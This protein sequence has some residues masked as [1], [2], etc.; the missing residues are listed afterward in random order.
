MVPR[1]PFGEVRR[2]VPH[3]VL[4]AHALVERRSSGNPSARM[5][6]VPAEFCESARVLPG[7]VVG[8]EY[9]RTVGAFPT[10]DFAAVRVRG[11]GW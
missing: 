2:L 6:R 9:V 10:N 7:R 5:G 8:K 4:D 11:A 1:H 3:K